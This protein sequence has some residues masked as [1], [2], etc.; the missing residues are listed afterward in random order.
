MAHRVT[1]TALI[2]PDK[3]LG[4]TLFN[5]H[6]AT[7]CAVKLVLWDKPG[8]A[9]NCFIQWLEFPGGGSVNHLRDDGP[10]G[11]GEE[12]RTEAERA[13][14]KMQSSLESD[15]LGKFWIPT[16]L[17]GAPKV[18]RHYQEKSGKK[19]M[20]WYWV[21]QTHLITS[22][23]TGIKVNIPHSSPCFSQ[24]SSRFRRAEVHSSYLHCKKIF[25]IIAWHL[26]FFYNQD[27]TFTVH[28]G[29]ESVQLE[30]VGTEGRKEIH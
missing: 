29:H 1:N 9:G 21:S 4:C 26:P 12:K 18:L 17:R 24:L 27:C 11:W 15:T 28:P 20:Y 19:F 13:P 8:S 2:W 25:E 16:Y 22:N 7:E 3:L 10:A 14:G 30:A 23:T 5:A 6:G